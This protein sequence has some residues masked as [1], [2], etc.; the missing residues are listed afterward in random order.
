MPENSKCGEKQKISRMKR[1]QNPYELLVKVQN[2][3]AT[4]EN[5]WLFL[6]HWKI[7]LP[8]ELATSLL[9]MHP[10]KWKV[11][12]QTDFFTPI[13]R[14]PFFTM[15]GRW[16]QPKCPPMDEWIDKMW[17]IYIY[18]ISELLFSLKKKGNCDVWCTWMNLEDIMLG[19]ISQPQND[20]Y[21]L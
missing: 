10:K 12:T 6:K 3:A 16:K 4:V 18:I 2:D 8:Y 14:A 21:D 9:G 19:K 11:G 13:F 20:K 5:I 7:E 15:A 17:G 1:N